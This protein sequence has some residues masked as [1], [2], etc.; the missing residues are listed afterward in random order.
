MGGFCPEMLVGHFTILW[1]VTSSSI[2]PD[3]GPFPGTVTAARLHSI[4]FFLY[5]KIKGQ[6]LNLERK[7]LN[8]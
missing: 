4:L 6:L 1:T 2:F 7:V 5:K 3:E 8:P